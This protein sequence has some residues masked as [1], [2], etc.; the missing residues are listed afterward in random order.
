MR[1]FLCVND[2]D[3]KSYPYDPL[4]KEVDYSELIM[5]QIPIIIAPALYNKSPVF[6]GLV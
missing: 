6:I 2:L 1:L 5:G 3:E 4:I